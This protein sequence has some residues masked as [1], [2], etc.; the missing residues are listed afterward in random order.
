M[1][2]IILISLLSLCSSIATAGERGSSAVSSFPS[3]L[4]DWNLFHI[5]NHELSLRDGVIPYTLKNPLF[6]DYA[7]KFRTIWVPSGQKIRYRQNGILDFPV[8]SVISKTF[9]YKQEDL[10][11]PGLDSDPSQLPQN[12]G[13]GDAKQLTGIYRIETRILLRR[14]SGWVGIPYVWDPDQKD[15]SLALIGKKKAIKLKHSEIGQREF[16][17]QVPNFNQCKACHV[18]YAEYSKLI[19]PIGPRAVNLNHDFEFERGVENQLEYWSEKGVLVGLA[20]REKRPTM[21][22]WNDQGAPVADRARSYLFANCAHCHG[23]SGPA[24]TS[25]LFLGLEV[26]SPIVLGICKTPVAIGNG[27]NE[28]MAYDIAPGDPEHSNLYHRLKSED[29]AVVRP[30]LGRSLAHQ[31]GVELI[32]QWIAQMEGACDE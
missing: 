9:G 31:K 1:S 28:G 13:V 10:S 2:V 16:T 25:G 19:K 30:E 23:G 20:A 15:A 4:S 26:T 6:S 11:I 22:S 18:K 14:E 17:Y 29:P 7:S 8:G 21:A 12:I 32:H 27:G 24:S 3:K 5:E